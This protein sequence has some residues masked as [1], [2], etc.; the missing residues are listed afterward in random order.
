MVRLASSYEAAQ[1]LV[2]IGVA[3]AAPTV[4]TGV[5]EVR[6][7][8]TPQQHVAVVRASANTVGSA[9]F[10]EAYLRRDRRRHVTLPGAWGS[11]VVGVGEL[12]AVICPTRSA[13]GCVGGR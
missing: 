12:R 10:L 8:D 9:L 3:A 13:R 11:V 6:G 5:A 1:R 7:L 2:L 4:G